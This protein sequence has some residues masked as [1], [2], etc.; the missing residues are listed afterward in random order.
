M[1]TH[2]FVVVV[3]FGFYFTF[4]TNTVFLLLLFSLVY[5]IL[6][7]CNLHVKVVLQVFV[8]IILWFNYYVMPMD[9]VNVVMFYLV[10]TSNVIKEFLP[11][12]N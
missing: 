9:V 2:N 8:Y 6:F 11:R 10:I 5:L 3:W 7:Y 1:T 12:D 4:K